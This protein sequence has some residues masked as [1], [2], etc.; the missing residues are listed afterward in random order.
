MADAALLSAGIA[1]VG[2]AG[3][4]AGGFAVPRFLPAFDAAATLVTVLGLLAD[5]GEPLSA[6]RARLPRVHLA[7][8]EVPTPW[9]RT[10]AAMRAV[11]DD[12]AGQELETIDGVKVRYDDGWALLV[13]GPATPVV[14]VWAEAADDDAAARRAATHARRL[15][16]LAG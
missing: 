9:E 12:L 10:G 8:L 13:P 16:Q 7:R 5:R 2:F 3:D 15:Q 4:G 14:Q 1:P 6:V 11:I